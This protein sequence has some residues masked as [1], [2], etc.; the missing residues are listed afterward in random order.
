LIFIPGGMMDRQEVKNI[1]E[2]MIFAS[3]KP[4]SISKMSG[5][6]NLEE[7]EVK[8]ILAELKN[9][10]KPRGLQ[11]IEVGGGY[12]IMTKPQY[13]FFVKEVCSHTTRL[14]QSALETLAIVAYC[15]PATKPEIEHLR[16]VNCDGVIDTLLERGLLKIV[17]RK[18]VVGKPFLFATT[19]KFLL[20][21]VND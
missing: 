3:E 18:D 14:T 8:E 2:C 12:K 9:D 5:I 11:L 17:G 21:F 7:K 16:G 4:L 15:Q 13:S 1:L 10:F 6:L 20:Y 19:D